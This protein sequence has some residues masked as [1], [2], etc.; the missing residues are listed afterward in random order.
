MKDLTKGSPLKLILFFT[1]PLFIGNLFQ[2]L[3]NFSDILIVGQTLGVK[4]LAA[5]GATG[6]LNYLI[7]GLSTGLTTGLSIVTATRFGARDYRGVRRSFAAGLIV[8]LIFTLIL[9]VIT[10]TFIDPILHVMETPT[11]IY[12]QAKQFIMVIFIGIFATMA[13][14]FLSNEIRALGDSKT[15]LWFL[16]IGTVI[17]VILELLFIIVFHWGVKGA[18]WATVI[19]QIISGVLCVIYI[20]RSFP[21]LQ[22]HRVDFV[23]CTKELRTQLKFGLPM[24]FQSS[25]ISVGSMIMAAALNSLGTTSVAATTSASKVDQLATLP[26]MSFGITMAT[27]AAQNFGAGEYDRI[28]KGVKQSLIASISFSIVV[29]FLII[30]GGKYVVMLFVGSGETAVLK[31]SQVYFNIVGVSYWLLAILFIIRYT[32]QGL[33]KSVVP[34]LAGIAELVMRAF[35]GLVLTG[36]MGYAGACFANPLAWFGSMAVL[37]SSYLRAIKHLHNLQNMKNQQQSE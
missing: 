33:G 27:F 11:E 17:N 2:Q 30:L 3:Y 34:T 26:M 28:I 21:M 15:P 9:T 12:A 5:V 8:S 10:L 18:A 1:F 31:L 24:A 13:F 20:Y 22:L 7:I 37:T 16:M 25:I 36:A 4:S 32:L 19:S 35:A 23:D 29:G 14:N 6:S